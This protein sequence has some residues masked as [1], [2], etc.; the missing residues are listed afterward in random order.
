MFEKGPFV[1]VYTRLLDSLMSSQE[2]SLW[3]DKKTMH[4]PVSNTHSLQSEHEKANIETTW[5]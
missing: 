3:R 5:L 4:K 2:A 1:T